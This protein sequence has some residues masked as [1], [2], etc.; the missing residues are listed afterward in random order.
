MKSLELFQNYLDKAHIDAAFISNPTNILYLTGYKGVYSSEVVVGYFFDP[1]GFLVVPKRG[2]A[3]LI[4]DRRYQGAVF[5]RKDAVELLIPLNK[6]RGLLD[7]C[8]E[9]LS[10]TGES[11]GIEE[12]YLTLQEGKKIV[13]KLK[14]KN[15]QI[16][17]ISEVLEK[18]RG[19]K[20]ADEIEKL[21]KA[22][23]ITDDAFSYVMTQ[24]QPGMTEKYVSNMIEDFFRRNNAGL[25]FETIVAS[26]TGSA[27]PH[28]T[29]SDKPIEENDMVVI[30]FGA[31][32]Q[33]YHAD[34]TRTICL[35][36]PTDEQQHIYNI[37]LEAQ[38]DAEK[39]IKPGMK[40]DKAFSFANNVF[41]KYSLEKYFTHALSH[42][43]GLAVHEEP[44]IFA[45]ATE[46]LEPGNVFSIEPGLYIP[47]KFGV[48]IEDVVLLTKNGCEV[49]SKSEKKLS[50]VL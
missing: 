20:T 3:K 40:A 36:K 2:K 29:T 33:Q 19:I 10:L 31:K 21:T 24:I 32:Y 28:H 23:K 1:D 22:Q 25:S 5:E 34:M 18:Q 45:K 4:V 8:V 44:V 6:K 38:I 7:F 17:D 15:K 26:S 27:T 16:E 43:V 39:N 49:L 12:L 14:V 11:F 46:V 9:Q 35:G 42:G 30:D 41:K 50:A 47:G 37:V 48:R 13:E